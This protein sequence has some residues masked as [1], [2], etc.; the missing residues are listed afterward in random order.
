MWVEGYRWLDLCS[1]QLW[2]HSGGR[3]RLASGTSPG[4]REGG[5][6]RE[7]ERERDWLTQSWLRKTDFTDEETGKAQIFSIAPGPCSQVGLSS[8]VWTVCSTGDQEYSG[9]KLLLGA[10]KTLWLRWWFSYSQCALGFIS[11]CA[12]DACYGSQEPDSLIFA[13]F[14]NS[15][16]NPCHHPSL[17]KLYSILFCSILFYSFR[18]C[19]IM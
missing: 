17:F 8:K 5:R 3:S 19:L 4:G 9:A 1:R 18:Q 13:S 2:W 14:H 16:D 11:L 15:W 12:A 10:L 6:Q 7:R